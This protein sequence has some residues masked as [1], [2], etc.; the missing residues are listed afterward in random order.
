MARGIPGL[1]RLNSRS[2]LGASV[3]GFAALLGIVGWF[4][5][6]ISQCVAEN[7][8]HIRGRHIWFTVWVDLFLITAFV[9][10]FAT[11]SVGNARSVL[12]SLSIIAVVMNVLGA[13]E[14]LYLHW[15]ESKAFGAGY[16]LLAIATLLLMLYLAADADLARSHSAETTGA[17]IMGGGIGGGAVGGLRNRFS[18]VGAGTAPSGAGISAPVGGVHE[19][20]SSSAVAGP[21]SFAPSTPGGAEPRGFTGEPQE[22]ASFVQAHESP[23]HVYGAGT[24][25]RAPEQHDASY[26]TG[27]GPPASSAPSMPSGAEPPILTA[28]PSSALG[29]TAASNSYITGGSGLPE[30]VPE[31]GSAVPPEGNTTVQRAEALYSYKASEDDPTEISFS[32]GDV[33]E[34]VDSSGKWWQARR[35]NGELGIV[36]SNYLQML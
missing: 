19:Y 20:G 18:K 17:G 28:A 2:L 13:D 33:L 15:D 7:R 31:S 34:I 5:A 10:L 1:D 25:V 36:P 32:K 3:L 4:T 35:S 8:G 12:L 24:E 29:E 27:F 21:T 14:G 30:S 6:F 11:G 9:F 26:P 23:E 16:L 22:N